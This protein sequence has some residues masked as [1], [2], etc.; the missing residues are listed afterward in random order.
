MSRKIKIL[1]I[2][3]N[4]QGHVITIQQGAL[5]QDSL[6]L[7]KTLEAVKQQHFDLILSEPQNLAIL[8][9]DK[10]LPAEPK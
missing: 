10:S 7:G 9:P 3:P 6:T 8:P 2:D 5:V 1:H 4:Y